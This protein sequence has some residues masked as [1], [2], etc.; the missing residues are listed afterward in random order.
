VNPP[1]S[2]WGSEELFPFEL[3][4]ESGGRF[5]RH[6]WESGRET[7]CSLISVSPGS[8]RLGGVPDFPSLLP[9]PGGGSCVE[10]AGAVQCPLALVEVRCYRLC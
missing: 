4:E 8:R 6:G 9:P 2:S 10:E 3:V 5:G 1:G 7:A